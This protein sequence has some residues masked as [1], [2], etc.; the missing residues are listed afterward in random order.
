M[1]YYVRAPGF[2]GGS[3]EKAMQQAQEIRKRDALAGHRAFAT[4]YNV[5]KKP[6]LALK[7]YSDAV[8]EQP[9]SP[10]TH[11]SLA[12]YQMTQKNYKVATTELET[13]LRLDPAFMPAYFRIGQIAALSSSDFA[14][15][16][17]SL[18]KYLGYTPAEDEPGLHRAWY[19]LGLI[20]EKQGRN[21]DA[22]Q[23][24]ATSLRLQPEQKDVTE[25]LKRVS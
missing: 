22:K 21:A 7:E 25:A 13:A 3:E 2:M 18:R 15:G 14:R 1:E 8:R 16:E 20:Y 24:Y 6:D 19:W 23:S 12:L 11:H 10:R 17:K 9:N 5:Q 4:I